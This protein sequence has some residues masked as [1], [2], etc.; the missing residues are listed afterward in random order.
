SGSHSPVDQ[1]A[2]AF[3][4]QLSNRRHKPVSELGD[5]LDVIVLAVGIAQ[6]S[7]QRPNVPREVSLL[8]KGVGPDA[9]YQF[10]FLNHVTTASYQDEQSFEGLGREGNRLP[11]AQQEPLGSL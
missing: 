7:A 1:N 6:G 2:A 9:L 11:I 8:D 5:R 3:L 10:I 4:R